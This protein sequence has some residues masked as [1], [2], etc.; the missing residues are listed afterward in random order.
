M[1]GT[2]A[3]AMPMPADFRH[4]DLLRRGKISAGVS[5]LMDSFRVPEGLKDP[6]D[7]KAYRK[8][9]RSYLHR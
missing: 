6:E 2:S 1:C 7:R 4:A 3:S 8:Y 9:I 5:G